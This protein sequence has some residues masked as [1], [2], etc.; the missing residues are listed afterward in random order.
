MMQFVTK[1]IRGKLAISFVLV[2]LVPILVLGYIG[3]RL[4]GDAIEKTEFAKLLSERELRKNEILN[5]LTTTINNLQY[6][7]ETGAATIAFDTL[8]SSIEF[9]RASADT[10][11]DTS[12]DVY[13]STRETVSKPIEAFISIHNSDVSGY[14]DVLLIGAKNGVVMY[15]VRQLSDLGANLK[16]GD[17]KDS[18]LAKLWSRVIE[19]GK[20]ALVDFGV[21]KPTGNPA[22][23]A[24]V[25]IMDS[26]GKVK[27]VVALRMGPQ[28]IVSSFSSGYDTDTTAGSYLVGQDLL[29]RSQSKF[30]KENSV[31]KKKIETDAAKNALAGKSET[32]FTRDY[33]NV[34]VLSSYAPLNLPASRALGA[35]FD[36][37]IVSEVAES[38]MRQPMRAILT[39]MGVIVLV[40][41]IIVIL[42]VF[43]LSREFA[44]PITMI[45]EIADRL[46]K[47]DLTVTVPKFKRSDEIGAL[48]ES[49]RS[50]LESMRAQT[51][52]LYEGIKIL[53]G[54]AAEISTA[55]TQLVTSTAE[56]ATSV[57]QTT[58]T[59]EEVKQAAKVANDNA[60]NVARISQQAVAVSTEGKKATEAAIQ[61]IG[62][63]RDQ[64]ESV[65]ETVVRL[66]EHSVAIEQIIASVQDLADQ[67]NLLAVNASIEAARAGEQGRG[68][69]VVAQEIKGLA[70]QSRESTLEVRSILEDVR[71]SVSAVVMAT[72]QGNKAVD[73]GVRQSTKAEE[74]IT[75]LSKAVETSSQAA[76]IIEVSAE[77][78][79][80]GI[81]QVA[82]AMSTINKAMHDSLAS[83]QQMEENAKRLEEL[84][85]QLHTLAQAFKIS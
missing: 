31:L 36:W 79:T 64:M 73:A 3:L 28:H 69:A 58:A 47:G 20:P 78:Q 17:L 66:S 15:S 7:N 75:T 30:E 52:R 55:I 71:K 67:S 56:T 70:D 13:K 35:D 11:F 44:R 45:S 72:E 38:E 14:D 5:Y 77:Q 59:L 10:P 39:Y 76:S 63:I 85:N 16:T 81:D 54:S 37:A 4:A 68:F 34:S 74:A 18:G 40:V 49:F 60:M 62:L 2:G 65:G 26:S 24:G 43:F 53:S 61:G 19:T 33:R 41:A 46:S 83:T 12:S 25:P 21:Y 51:G 80:A 50:M 9:S 48:A 84:G 6:L 8:Y 82:L 27:G 1:S 23:F 22:A 29:L 57:N 42:L 32:A